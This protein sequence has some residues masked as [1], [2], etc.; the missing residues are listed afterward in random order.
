LRRR[1]NG[2]RFHLLGFRELGDLLELSH[3]HGPC[4]AGFFR[5]QPG[6]SPEECSRIARAAS[7]LQ[8]MHMI[9]LH[10]DIQ[11]SF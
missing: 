4:S 9:D 3:R 6:P 11:I 1:A 10:S 2:L 8:N 7:A 5:A